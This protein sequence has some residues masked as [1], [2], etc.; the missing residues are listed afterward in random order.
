V[1]TGYYRPEMTPPEYRGETWPHRL[2]ERSDEGEQ[3]ERIIRSPFPPA[4]IGNPAED[5][6][7]FRAFQDWGSRNRRAEHPDWCCRSCGQ[8]LGEQSMRTNQTACPRCRI[9]AGT[10]TYDEWKRQNTAWLRKSGR[11]QDR[12]A[13]AAAV[14][15]GR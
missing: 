7:A 10:L 8:H 2:V 9:A 4:R 15:M 1:S 12:D 11:L 6:E 14:G 3:V 13:E 5:V